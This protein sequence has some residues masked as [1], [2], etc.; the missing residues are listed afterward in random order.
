MLIPDAKITELESIATKFEDLDYF[1]HGVVQGYIRGL[2]VEGDPGIGKTYGA[3]KI[4]SEYQALELSNIKRF[5]IIG[6][7][8]ST[9]YLYKKLYEFRHSGMVVMLDDC[10]IADTN[11]WNTLKHALDSGDKRMVQW[12]KSSSELKKDGIPDTFEFKGGVIFSTN[13]RLGGGNGKKDAHMGAMVSR[14]HYLN[15]RLTEREKLIR[16]DQVV[17]PMLLKYQITEE[18]KDIILRFI[19]THLAD[20]RELSLR[21][22]T[23]ITDLYIAFP[24][25][26]ERMAVSSV[27]LEKKDV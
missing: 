5:E 26:W 4:F 6:G 27:T 13:C 16:I 9:F 21:T 22:V 20:L 18:E 3:S 2:I 12:Y 11:G 15:M 7:N 14:C 10:E 1:I 25:R 8:L 17:S 23:K 24:D 19:I